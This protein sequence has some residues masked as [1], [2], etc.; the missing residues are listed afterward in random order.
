MT[1]RLESVQKVGHAIMAETT[2]DPGA[3]GILTRQLRE[4]AER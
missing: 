4:V 1:Y 2:K 3:Y